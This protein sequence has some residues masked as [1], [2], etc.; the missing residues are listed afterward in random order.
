VLAAGLQA[1]FDGAGLVA[2]TSALPGLVGLHFG[3]H[4][5]VDYTDARSTDEAAY[6][7]LFHAMLR[8]GVALAPGAYEVAFPGL[9]HDDAV[10]D[11]IAEAAGEAAAEVVAARSGVGTSAPG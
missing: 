10:I 3:D 5:P 1:A 4:R 11:R 2:R 9:A 7:A 6:A 8:R